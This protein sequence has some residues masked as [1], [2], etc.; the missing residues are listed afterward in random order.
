MEDLKNIKKIKLI[1]LNE[2]NGKYYCFDVI[3]LKKFIF[4]KHNNEYKNPYTNTEF[5][6]QTSIKY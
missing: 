2:I 1:M 3:A 4:Q 6:K 5:S